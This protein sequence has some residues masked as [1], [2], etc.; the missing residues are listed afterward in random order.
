VVDLPEGFGLRIHA[1]GRTEALPD[2]GTAR[3]FL[4]RQ[5]ASGNQQQQQQQ[6]A[7]MQREGTKR[8]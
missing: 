3:G 2:A 7:V 8:S 5:R 1:A 6:H 4:Q